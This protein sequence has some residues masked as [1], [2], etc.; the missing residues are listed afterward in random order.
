[1][2]GRDDPEPDVTDFSTRVVEGGP[3]WVLIR[4]LE[5]LTVSEE[6]YPEALIQANNLVRFFLGSF[7][8]FYALL[9]Q[10][11]QLTNSSL[12]SESLRKSPR[13]E[14]TPHPSPSTALQLLDL[15]LLCRRRGCRQP[16]F[17]VHAACDAVRGPGH[18]DE[19]R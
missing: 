14:G 18:S 9:S 19:M 10:L 3:D 7:H 4:S 15:F 11:F 5:W 8:R 1:M 16:S 6:T 12:P 2:P 17:G 13:R